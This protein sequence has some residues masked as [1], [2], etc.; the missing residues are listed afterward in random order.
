MKTAAG[1]VPAPTISTS[2]GQRPQRR[3]GLSCSETSPAYDPA[4]SATIAPGAAASTA[5]AIVVHGFAA[6]P[7]LVAP[8][9]DGST[10]SLVASMGTSPQASSPHPASSW[11]ASSP[12]TA[13]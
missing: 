1:R 5:S 2:A 10:S 9:Y 12:G 7:S 11:H 6:E 8:V 3:T 13:V 4:A